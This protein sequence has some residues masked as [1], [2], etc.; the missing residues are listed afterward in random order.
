MTDFESLLKILFYGE[1]SRAI[2]STGMNERSS[3]SHTIFRITIESREKDV[4][5]DCDDSSPD[6]IPE[7]SD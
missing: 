1:K 2:A 7:E 3:R 5:N 4:E 6:T